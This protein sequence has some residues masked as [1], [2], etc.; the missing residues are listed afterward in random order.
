MEVV[1]PSYFDVFRIP[2]RRGRYLTT[3]IARAPGAVVLSEGA[4]RALWPNSDALGKQLIGAN[5]DSTRWTVVGIVAD[6]RYREYRRPRET[7]YFAHH[8][9]PFPLAATMLALRSAGGDV[10][11]LVPQ[12]RAVIR[13]TDPSVLLSEAAS[14]ESH[15]DIPLAQPRFNALL[16]GAFSTSALLIVVVGL[17]AALAFAVRM[18]ARELAIRSATRAAPKRYGP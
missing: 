3:Q 6:T 1:S 9:P 11:D 12:I 16:L 10:L 8:Q 13:D 17:Y 18:R 2:L 14:L 5:I 15:L 7:I 4:A